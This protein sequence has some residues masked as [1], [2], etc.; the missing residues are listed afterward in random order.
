MGFPFILCLLY[1][2][3]LMQFSFLLSGVNVD[4]VRV[5]VAAPAARGEANNELLEFMGK[6]WNPQNHYSHETQSFKPN[7]LCSILS[8]LCCEYLMVMI[9]FLMQVLGLR[10]NDSSKRME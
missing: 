9:V 4:D 10:S 2:S 1:F 5:T 3:Q 8:S 6:V 7:L